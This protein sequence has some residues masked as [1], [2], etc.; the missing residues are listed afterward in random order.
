MTLAATPGDHRA[1]QL[2]DIDAV[3]LHPTGATIDLQAGRIHDQAVDTALLEE[4]RQPKAVVARLIAERNPRP[5]P[6]NF[7]TRSPAP[8]PAWRPGLRRRRL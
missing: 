4:P 7:A 5:P 1:Q 6:R 3:G 8:R 2:L